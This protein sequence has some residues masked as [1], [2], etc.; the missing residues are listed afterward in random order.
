[1]L[2]WQ[3]KDYIRQIVCIWSRYKLKSTKAKMGVALNLDKACCKRYSVL[4]FRWGEYIL[5]TLVG[6]KNV[7]SLPLRVILYSDVQELIWAILINCQCDLHSAPQWCFISVKSEN[8]NDFH[9]PWPY[10][11][12]V[13]KYHDKF[14][15]Y[16]LVKSF[17]EWWLQRFSNFRPCHP[18]EI[19]SLS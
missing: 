17:G 14:A 12:V 7:S 11:G 13:A 18:R 2:Y 15:V 5:P 16:L 19:N 3:L 4:T 9:Y 1:M 6:W 10:R 8:Y